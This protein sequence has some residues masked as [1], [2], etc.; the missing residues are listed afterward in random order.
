[1]ICLVADDDEGDVAVGAV[2]YFEFDD[3]ASVVGEVEGCFAL[4]AAF[5]YVACVIKPLVKSVIVGNV[6]L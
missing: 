2:K 4:W 6:D 1:M 5:L 3:V